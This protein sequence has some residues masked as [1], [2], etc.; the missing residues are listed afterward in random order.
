MDPYAKPLYRITQSI[1]YIFWVV[2]ITL[3]A[4]F[5]LKFMG[6]NSAAPFTQFVYDVSY[7]LVAP[8]YNIVPSAVS[9][10]NAL[11]WSTLVALAVYWIIAWGLVTLVFM[12]RPVT[13]L[14]ARSRLHEID[15]RRH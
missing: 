4:R 15:L 1:W 10:A 8:F 3:L 2:E 14:E 6:A 5:V 12:L 13:T 9:A 7:P 11:E